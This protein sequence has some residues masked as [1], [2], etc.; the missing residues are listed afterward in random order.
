MKEMS[1]MYYRNMIK[2][3]TYVAFVESIV[4]LA[5]KLGI[6]TVGEFIEDDAIYQKAKEL[7]ITF[8]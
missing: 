4:T 8:V 7:G 1:A 3:L 6:K 2:N 5:R